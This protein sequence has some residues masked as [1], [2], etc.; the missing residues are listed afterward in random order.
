MKVKLHD[1]KYCTQ[2]LTLMLTCQQIWYYL[3]NITFQ[4][5]MI[6]NNYRL[7][8]ILLFGICMHK[9]IP[10]H[11]NPFP[12][13]F[14]YCC[15]CM[16]SSHRPMHVPSY[17]ACSSSLWFTFPCE[18]K[19]SLSCTRVS[20]MVWLIIRHENQSLERWCWIKLIVGYERLYIYNYE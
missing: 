20:S 9:N 3:H 10:L 8:F 16:P 14:I 4:L 18:F 13:A 17:I 5:H 1:S 6:I 7:L 11:S 2:F 19:P 15:Y 12:F